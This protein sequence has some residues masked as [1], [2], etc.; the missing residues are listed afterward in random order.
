MQNG[1]SDSEIFKKSPAATRIV[2]TTALITRPDRITFRNP[3]SSAFFLAET[4]VYILNSSS[5]VDCHVWAKSGTVWVSLG[6]VW[7][8]SGP[9]VRIT[10]F[11]ACML[12][13]LADTQVCFLNSSS[14]VVDCHV[15]VK[16]GKVW[17]SLGKVWKK[18]GPRVRI[19]EFVDCMLFI[20]A[21]RPSLFFELVLNS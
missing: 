15:W 3:Y 6:K 10:E 2:P 4:Q 17:V 16:S 1:N 14:T 20:L 18:S 5:T 19:T 11:V 12:F 7:A 13:I 8:K 21:E 9:R